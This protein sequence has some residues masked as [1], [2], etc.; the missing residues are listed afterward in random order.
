MASQITSLTIVY[1]TVYSGTDLRKYQSSASLAFVRAIHRR[2]PHTKASN[3]ENDS[4]WWHRHDSTAISVELSKVSPYDIYANHNFIQKSN[5]YVKFIPSLS[6]S[7]KFS[8]WCIC[9]YAWFDYRERDLISDYIQTLL[10]SLMFINP[11]NDGKHHCKIAFDHKNGMLMKYPRKDALYYSK[12]IWDKRAT[13]C[14][15]YDSMNSFTSSY[16]PNWFIGFFLSCM[17]YIV[18]F[19]HEL[20]YNDTGMI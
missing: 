13:F 6:E 3:A 4:I 7:L 17:I 20:I 9:F 11:R 19:V 1:P 2:I 5:H 14:N 12:Y 16:K 10:S 15:Q 18:Y 8:S